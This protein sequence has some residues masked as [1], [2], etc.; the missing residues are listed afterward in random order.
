MNLKPVLLK[1]RLF[2]RERQ[3]RAGGN[4]EANAWWN[5]AGF[6]PRAPHRGHGGERD[7]R[8]AFSRTPDDFRQRRGRKNQRNAVQQQR[9]D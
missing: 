1:N 3:R 7:G 5:S 9:Q 4:G 8:F 6:L 2:Q